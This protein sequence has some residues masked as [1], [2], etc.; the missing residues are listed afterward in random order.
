MITDKLAQFFESLGADWVLWLLIGLLFLALVVMIERALFFRRATVNPQAVS[1]DIIEAMR[2]GGIEG[3]KQELKRLPGMHQ[4]VVLS[5][6]DA[7]DHGVD[8]LEDVIFASLTHEKGLYD[9]RLPILGTLGNAAPYIG[10]F[11][12]VIGI[13]TAFSALGSGLDGEQLRLQVMAQIGE[14]LVA[15]AV[16]LGV[17]IPC[18]VAFNYFKN[19]LKQM[20]ADAEGIARLLLAHLKAEHLQS[21]VKD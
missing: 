8:A 6:L 12:T 20:T 19:R 11:G 4:N 3:A 5:A 16:G 15:T 2:Q 18:V 14:A 10:L 13:L 21:K 7:W 17:A 1:K 9:K